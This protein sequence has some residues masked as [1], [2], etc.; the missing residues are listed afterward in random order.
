MSPAT[1]FLIGQRIA[2]AVANFIINGLI[3]WW[4]HGSATRLELWGDHGYAIDLLLT[5]ALIP[6]ITWLIVRPMLRKHAAAGKAPDLTGVSVPLLLRWMSSATWPG[7]CTSFALGLGV[8]GLGTVAALSLIGPPVFAGGD[9]SW[10]K[11]A[12]SAM[13][14]FVMQPVLVFAALRS[15]QL[16]PAKPA[17]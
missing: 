15:L 9:F 11:G 12:F 17:Y 8:C 3:A 7:F 4:L 10:F 14:A 13:V 6:S 5:A 1:H 2:P 16:D